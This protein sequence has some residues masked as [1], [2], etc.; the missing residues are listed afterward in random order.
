MFL[1]LLLWSSLLF[2]AVNSNAASNKQTGE[3]Y[4]ILEIV[5]HD[6]SGSP[7]ADDYV[8]N[9]KN[10]NITTMTMKRFVALR[11]EL[12]GKYD[13]I[14]ISQGDY[15]P[16][17]LGKSSGNAQAH[18]TTNIMNDITDLRAEEIKEFYIEKGLPIFIYRNSGSDQDVLKYSNSKLYK[19]FSSYLKNQKDNVIFFRNKLQNDFAKFGLNGSLES[20]KTRPRF[21][22]TSAP[23]NEQVMKK[24]DT[25][26]FTYNIINYQHFKNKLLTVNL[27]IDSDFNDKYTNE[28]IVASKQVQGATGTI[29]YTLPAGY[30][31]PRYWKV[32]IVDETSA[33]KDYE[34][35]FVK[36][37]DVPAVIKV[38]QIRKGNDA[39][40]LLNT[41]NM[42]PS[43]LTRANEY[44]IS[45][46]VTTLTDFQK[47]KIYEP[48]YSHE[49]INGKYDMIIFGFADCYNGCSK[50][51]S[52]NPN[53]VQ[54]IKSFIASGQ[55]VMFTHDVM[56]G[57]NNVWVN[58]FGPIVGQIQPQTDLGNGA[59]NR[60][61]STK[62][63]NN[64][65]MTNYPFELDDSITIATTHNQYYTLDLEDENV[66]A[67]YNIDGSPRDVYDSWN[68]YYTYSKGNVTYSGTGHTIGFP[69][70]EQKLFV[71]TM[72][73]AFFGSNHAPQLTVIS[74]KENETIPSNQPIELSYKVE[75]LDL[76]DR[77]FSTKVWINDQEVYAQNDVPNG[78]TIIQS[79]P[80]NMPNGG[81]AKMKIE[82]TDAR[83]AK[84][85]KEFQVVIEKV[86]ANME[87]NRTISKTLAP[88]DESITMQYTITPK[89]LSL[90]TNTLLKVT[91]IAF[92]EKL[93]AGI[94][95]VSLPSGFTKQGTVTE[96]YT[97]KGT[98]P[99]ISFVKS[100]KTYIA[101]PQTF[102][103]QVKP[104]KKGTFSL[105]QAKLTYKDINAQLVN[106]S[107]NT[108]SF[109]SDYKITDVTLPSTIFVNRG[110]PKNARLLLN[111]LPQEATIASV[112]WSENSN[113]QI[114]S[115]DRNGIITAVKEGTAQVTAKVK[116]MFGN[117]KTTT[118][119]VIVRIPV[120]SITINDFTVHVGETI[121]I[122]I[123]VS[124]ADAKKA[125]SYSLGNS[126]YA[127]INGANGTITGLKEGV[128]T[129]T[130]QAFNKNDELIEKTVTV[131]VQAIPVTAVVVSPTV[132]NIN[133]GETTTLTATVAPNDAT[134]KT[135]TWRSSNPNI[136]SVDENGK[137]TGL[138]TGQVT[139]TAQAHNGV[140][141]TAIVHVGSPLTGISLP[142][143][144]VVQKGKTIN[145][146]PYIA[147]IPAN[148][149]TKIV[150]RSF[151]IENSYYAVVDENGE[152][153]A[154]RLGETPLTVK[155]IDENGKTWTASTVIRV[156]EH[157]TDPTKGGNKDGWLY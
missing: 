19:H 94:E 66:I 86:S 98:L 121:S 129:L 125:V 23:L 101:E 99:D 59:P 15:N 3:K 68:H 65:L 29:S 133:I 36:F 61:T 71:N 14:V 10:L 72:Y 140:I 93:P 155:L 43:F 22:L 132:V 20:Y 154:K 97:I 116:D 135:I 142:E 83:G 54:S 8:N 143:T 131:T 150:S 144:L 18:N 49:V 34:K 2:P 47:S 63:V 81:T 53:A 126:L 58:E 50:I 141:G 57:A 82:A 39:S 145:V 30:S 111:I 44:S 84:V 123:T 13:A 73:R 77:T 64:G 28:E 148:A 127:E 85:T 91:N 75:D 37:Q 120:E 74:P 104:T 46:D 96:G 56:F 147:P 118:M 87:V 113:G 95:V 117:V 67:W 136:A 42:N 114:I 24:G 110:V 40:S 106:L 33:L 27:Y 90:L 17:K 105:S 88:V 55:S 130:V 134:Y 152:V 35:G 25:L 92:E 16:E 103:I 51:I 41:K 107:F 38:L 100:G 128:T 78:T 108:L 60:S 156:V 26:S 70:E 32:E 139:I 89:P 5:S 124:P 138:S 151:T 52:L 11:D 12:D 122:P 1:V 119:T 7:L 31:G 48:N 79:L 76:V 9:T 149:T 157:A 102:A 6:S 112:E 62:Q 153:T 80:H 69:E 115:I 4:E 146:L 45:I 21:F 109:V 137:V